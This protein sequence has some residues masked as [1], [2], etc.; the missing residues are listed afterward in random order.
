VNEH[1]AFGAPYHFPIVSSPV[2]DKFVR[3]NKP[4]RTARC[5]CERMI[6][7]WRRFSA[8]MPIYLSQPPTQPTA[9]M[10]G[11]TKP[12]SA[13]TP[14]VSNVNVRSSLHTCLCTHPPQEEH[15]HTGENGVLWAKDSKIY[16]R[17]YTIIYIACK[18]RF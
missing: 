12:N 15:I 16:R 14:S 11:C 6:R 10:H 17:T 13:T 2:P 5:M 7:V 4:Y 1:H 9:S 18:T 8:P 3:D